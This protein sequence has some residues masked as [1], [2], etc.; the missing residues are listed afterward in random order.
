ML[1]GEGDIYVGKIDGSDVMVCRGMA[2]KFDAEVARVDSE[3]VRADVL[4]DVL[5]AKVVGSSSIV[6]VN[7]SVP[8]A[9]DCCP[10]V[11]VNVFVLVLEGVQVNKLDMCSGGAGS[12]SVDVTKNGVDT[13]LPF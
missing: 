10:I 8:N 7:F 1:V 3:I 6:V 13:T 9:V 12:V 4:V 5:V 11:V 2:V